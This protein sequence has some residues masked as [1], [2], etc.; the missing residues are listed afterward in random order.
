M[1]RR[2]RA[3]YSPYWAPGAPP[4]VP[5]A[6]A[7]GVASASPWPARAPAPPPLGTASAAVTDSPPPDERRPPDAMASVGAS[8]GDD[9]AVIS[10]AEVSVDLP[11]TMGVSDR[12]AIV[13]ASLALDGRSDRGGGRGAG[14]ALR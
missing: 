9:D 6:L 5:R 2:N 14:V 7:P 13:A 8:A 4:P 3:R 12:G 10:S 1:R 11:V